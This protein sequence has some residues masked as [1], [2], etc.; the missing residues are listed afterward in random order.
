MSSAMREKP[1]LG[2]Q[3]DHNFR[4]TAP[5]AGYSRRSAGCC[6]AWPRCH[7]IQRKSGLCHRN[8]TSQS[9]RRYGDR[10]LLMRGDE[11]SLREANCCCR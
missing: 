6:R 3:H 2:T 5:K 11:I 8:R 4:R 9:D 7:R 1:S 10:I